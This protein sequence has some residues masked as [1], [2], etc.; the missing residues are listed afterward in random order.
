VFEPA[1]WDEA[2]AEIARRLPALR[3]AHGRDAVALVAGNPSAH[4]IG[5][6]ADF[7]AWRALGTRNVYTAVHAGPDAAAPVASGLLYGHWMSV[8][9]PDIARADLLI[10]LGANPVV[11]NGSMWTVPDFRGKAKAC[12][13]RGGRLVV[14][15]P[16]RTET[17]ALA[18]AHHFIRPGADAF[19]LAGMVHTLFAEDLANPGGLAA[20]VERRRRRAGGGGPF[21]TRGGGRPLRP[22]GR[23]HPGAGPG[24]RHAAGQPVRP[25]RHLHAGVR[26]AGQLAGGRAQHPDRPPGHPRRSDVPASRPRLR[27]TPA[28]LPGAGAA[29]RWGGTA[30]GCAAHRR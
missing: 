29:S 3:A 11:S 26:H 13:P 27:R 17:A 9:V 19:L 12:R 23:H 30:A 7:R 16:R 18:D 21:S 20:L 25:H 22:P 28:A 15:D 14:I 4:K 2:W 24:W 6:H 8:P 1:T 5:L 10:V